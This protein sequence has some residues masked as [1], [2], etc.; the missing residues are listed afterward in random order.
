MS[1]PIVEDFLRINGR[2]LESVEFCY[3]E[4]S[5]INRPEG[6]DEASLRVLFVFLSPG[7]TRS[8]SNTFTV[9][10]HYLKERMGDSV[11]VDFCYLPT[12]KDLKVYQKVG[13]SFLFGAA[14]HQM[15]KDFD[16][17]CISISILPE[18]WN[19]PSIFWQNSIPLAYQDRMEDESIPL[20]ITGGT[21][22]TFLDCAYGQVGDDPEKTTL[23]DGVMVGHAE[24][25]L[26]K[27]L[28]VTWIS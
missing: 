26:D 18:I 6:F 12:Q 22:S 8:V 5:N 17:V 28:S 15:W 16:V 7:V 4:D 27:I 24:V 20:I 2:D 14:S 9:L 25:G 19:V 23:M 11:F 21:C 3:S 1:N 13:M 10:H